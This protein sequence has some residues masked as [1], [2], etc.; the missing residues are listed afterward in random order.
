MSRA[1]RLIV[2][3]ALV[4]S[5]SAPKAEALTIIRDF[6]GGTPPTNSIGG[7]NLPD[8]FN[9]ACDYWEA[10]IKDNFTLTLHYLWY[11]SGFGTSHVLVHQ[12]ST[13]P[14]REDEG[15]IYV[16]NNNNPL[17]DSYYL[18]PNPKLRCGA[19]SYQEVFA[20]L[21][22]GKVNVQR[23]YGLPPWQGQ[24]TD[25]YTVLVYEIGH[26]LGFAIQNKGF[27]ASTN[28]GYIKLTSPRPYAKTRLPLRSDNKG[29]LANLDYI[30]GAA[31]L[32]GGSFTA[33]QGL[34]IDD[35]SLAAIAQVENF[36]NVVYGPTTNRP[37]S[38]FMNRTSTNT[39]LSWVGPYGGLYSVQ[40]SSNL[41][42]ASWTTVN[43]VEVDYTNSGVCTVTVPLTPGN[44]FYRLK[45]K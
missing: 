8:I 33:C 14:Y 4:L 37:P 32:L 16:N 24:Q 30:N 7:G 3:M 13:K 44:R 10:R 20:D 21:G 38:L 12:T 6:I 26:A 19:S 29:I 22:H 25:L 15:N 28:G 27:Q 34:D 18:D 11:T 31:S 36:T 43:A 39:A 40:T 9:A 42:T 2:F 45:H 35:A 5:W 1:I 23:V 41:A 17:N